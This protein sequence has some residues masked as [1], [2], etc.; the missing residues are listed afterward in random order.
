M[1]NEL[2]EMDDNLD[3]NY[4]IG[5]DVLVGAGLDLNFLANTATELAQRGYNEYQAR[6]EKSKAEADAETK[7]MAI[8]ALDVNAATA[9]ADYVMA[10][11]AAKSSP[12]AAADVRVAS[13]KNVADRAIQAIQSAA[14]GLPPA[15]VKKRL[16]A[17]NKAADA[18]AKKADTV[19]KSY[20]AAADA[21]KTA[22]TN[23]SKAAE[24]DAKKVASG[25]VAH[26]QA[27]LLAKKAASDAASASAAAWAK[28]VGMASGRVVSD[29][30]TKKIAEQFQ[31]GGENF[32]DKK[33]A[34]VPVWGW[35]LGAAGAGGLLALLLRRRGGR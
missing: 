19:N 35:G 12:S 15:A 28:I 10:E 22:Q 11:L 5:S 14:I 20:V 13:A 34:G 16:D 25:E 7:G 17:A 31:S 24:G 32:F 3:V 18:A 29:A 26:T 8:I 23:L 30:E 2:D 21:A 6:E 33:Y 4:V 9:T 1:S 27:D